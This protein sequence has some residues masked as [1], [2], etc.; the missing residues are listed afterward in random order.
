MR[1]SKQALRVAG[2]M[3][4]SVAAGHGRHQ[5]YRNGV[6]R[7]RSARRRAWARRTP[8]VRLH[9]PAKPAAPAVVLYD[10]YDN[11]G[12]ELDLVA[13]LRGLVRPLRQRAGRRLRRALGQT[14]NIDQVDAAGVYYNG[15]GPAA[16]VN[17]ASTTNASGLPG[18]NVATRTNLSLTDS[19]GS[20]VDSDPIAG[21]A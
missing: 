6:G 21:H 19:G 2:R 3:D 11:A 20:F 17:L 12:R 18:S 14:W 16:S 5:R 9:R 10:Q 1:S 4:W 15:A 7:R 8:R 13:E